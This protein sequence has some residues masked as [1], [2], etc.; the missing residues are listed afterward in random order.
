MAAFSL[1]ERTQ[2]MLDMLP[3]Y[4][5]DDPNVVTAYTAVGNEFG[6]LEQAGNDYRLKWFPANADDTYGTLGMWEMLL[7]LPVE[8]VGVTVEARRAQVLSRLRARSVAEGS[9]WVA[10]L[11]E[12]LAPGWSHIEG[13]GEYEVTIRLPGFA[14]TYTR[15]VAESFARTITPAHLDIS[16]IDATGFIIGINVVGDEL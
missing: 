4:L 16:V 2:V 3:P 8:P 15:S 13:P 10:R 5:A 11:S 1:G 12:A 9:E 6:R 7:G 14:G